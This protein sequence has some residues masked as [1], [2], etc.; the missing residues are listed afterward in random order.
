[1][2]STTP[3]WF[4][5]CCVAP[6]MPRSCDSTE[7]AT[8]AAI[9]GD[10]IPMP[11]P[12][13]ARPKMTAMSALPGATCASAIIDAVTR[14]LEKAEPELSADLAD[15]GIT[16]AGGALSQVF[17][18]LVFGPFM[19]LGGRKMTFLAAKPCPKDLEFVIQLVE[20]GKVALDQPVSSILPEFSGLRP[21]Q[22]YENPLQP[23]E[24]VPVLAESQPVDAAKVTFR[25]LLAHNSGLPAWRPL[26]LQPDAPSAWRMAAQTPFYYPTGR[27]VVYSDLH[28]SSGDTFGV[29]WPS[30]CKSTDLSPQEKALEFMLFDLS[31][32]V[33]PPDQPPQPPPVK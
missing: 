1:M 10:D 4:T 8:D 23:G 24:F 28:V 17:K 26:Y 3:I 7:F 29:P 25:N 22:P 18:S 19:S 5:I 32:C 31:S 20:E 12:D 11:T 9:A 2:P 21:V 16:L 15:N 13:N 6:A 30:G 14:T 33:I 27:R